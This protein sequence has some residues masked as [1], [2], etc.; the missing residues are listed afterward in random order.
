MTVVH[1]GIIVHCSATRPEWMS[2]N[3]T[4]EQMREI[5]RWH[6]EER[7]WRMIG[8]HYVVGRNG[9][10]V[11]ARPLGESGAHAKG[12]NSDIGIC[13]IGGFGSDADDL[14]VEHY[15]SE[16]LSS[17]Y[18]LISDLRQ[19]HNIPLSKVIGHNRVGNKA[20]P[21]FRV[22][23]WLGG[24]DLSR[25]RS[26]ERTKGTQSKTVKASA[27]TIAASAGSAVATVSSLDTNAQ[28][29]VLGFT[30]LTIL[31]GLYIMKE[32]LSAWAAGWR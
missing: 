18:K 28:Y 9:E 4:D 14:A 5:D 30:G 21:G 32:R 20:C 8:Y 3:T 19:H 31:L 2:S 29:I 27:A 1:K 16:Q 7:K 13:L 22:Q 24:E 10:V 6:R 17:L 26:V 23:K 12:H 11:E 25:N 15:T